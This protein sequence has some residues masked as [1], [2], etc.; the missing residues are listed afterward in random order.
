MSKKRSSMLM[1]YQQQHQQQP[2]GEWI[3]PSSPRT[4]AATKLMNMTMTS[5]EP[6]FQPAKKPLAKP[7]A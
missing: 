4:R 1:N 6:V 3:A 5:A 2:P 7:P